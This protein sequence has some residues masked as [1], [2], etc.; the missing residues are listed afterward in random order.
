MTQINI[1]LC[2]KHYAKDDRVISTSSIN[3][4]RTDIGRVPGNVLVKRKR[5]CAKC[6]SYYF[7]AERLL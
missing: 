4:G 1:C 7:T 6:K 3:N 2:K 5:H